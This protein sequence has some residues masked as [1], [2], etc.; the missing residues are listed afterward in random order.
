MWRHRRCA[1]L[2]PG[3]GRTAPGS[4]RD[5][6]RIAGDPGD[7]NGTP[8]PSARPSGK[9][10]PRS[11]LG[12]HRTGPGR[13]RPGLHAPGQRTGG[14]SADADRS[15]SM[16]AVMWRLHRNQAYTAGLALTTLTLLL[17]TSGISMNHPY[18]VITG[19][20][21]AT[22]TVP[23]LLGLFWGAPFL[24]AEFEGGT[25]NLAWTQGISRRRWLA[26]NISWA[27]LAAGLWSAIMAALVSWWIVR[28]TAPGWN[29]TDRLEN[30]IG[31]F[32]I[33]GIV[34]V[35]YSM[36][37]V[38]LGIAAGA[39]FR[40]VVPAMATT[41][42]GFVAVRAVIGLYLRPHYIPPVVKPGALTA[43]AS[44]PGAVNVSTAIIGPDGH[45]YGTPPPIRRSA[46]A[47]R[48]PRAWHPTG[49][50][51]SGSTS[52]RAD[53]GPSRASRRPSLSRSPQPSSP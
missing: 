35:A 51:W 28:E 36:F 3:A 8:D 40:R 39:V 2:P 20:V 27:L 32:D 41:L 25:H 31:L 6:A 12:S 13:H 47:T 17:L 30:H 50:T 19:L 9:F 15:R 14:R 53:S 37:A 48:P 46:I 4:H 42:A 45:N 11:I 43:T 10:R 26:R 23:L 1:G 38:A 7:T 49:S 33:Q 5:P 34:P 22:I 44:P 18:L 21:V 29:A 24:A 16:N 52:L